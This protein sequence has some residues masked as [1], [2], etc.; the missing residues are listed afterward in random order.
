[1]N[2]QDKDGETAVHMAAVFNNTEAL[3]LLLDVPGADV[4]IQDK[5]GRTAVHWAAEF[6]NTEALKLLLDHTSLTALT[7]NQKKMV[8]WTPVMIAVICKRLEALAM[9][10]AD[11]RVDLDT[12]DNEGQSL[13]EWAR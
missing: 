3:K 12:T 10:C 7:L 1:M 11:Q 4:N 6:N 13:E 9:L 2:I 8:G 5:D